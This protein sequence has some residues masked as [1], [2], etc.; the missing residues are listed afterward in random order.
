MHSLPNV[1]FDDLAVRLAGF[2]LRVFA[3]FGL[4]GSN[5]TIPGIGLSIEDFVWR[6]LE[7]L[8]RGSVV[9][10]P[11]KGALFSLLARA[12][13]NDIID[14]LRKAAYL[15]DETRSA[16][17][18]S[19]RDRAALDEFPSQATSVDAVLYKASYRDRIL[20]TLAGEPDLREVAAT[21]LDLDLTKAQEIAA[22]VGIS[23]VEYQN[24]KKR[25]RRRLIEFHAEEVAEHECAA[26]E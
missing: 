7:D 19:E 14:A 4:G 16:L 12:L 8:A 13:R 11:Q 20:S 9:Y 18:S 22:A 15:R 10:D 24:R 2:G 25:M 6:V 26:E 23:V 21:I 1:D 17:P 3:E 5:A